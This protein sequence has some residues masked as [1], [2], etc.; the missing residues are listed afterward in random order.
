M[1]LLLFPIKT[2]TITEELSTLLSNQSIQT[3]I[4]V[5]KETVN[6]HLK[7]GQV[8]GLVIYADT[9][10]T[11]LGNC[12][13]D[14]SSWVQ[15][16]GVFV[17]TDEM[18]SIDR[19]EDGIKAGVLHH[20]LSTQI[21]LLPHYIERFRTNQQR[22]L[23]LVSIE[24]KITLA[25]EQFY[26]FFESFSQPILIHNLKEIILVNQAFLDTFGYE[27][28]TEIIGK[29]PLE[30]I[31]DVS[32][33]ATV[34]SVR[35]NIQKGKQQFVPRLKL[36]KKD[37]SRF[38]AEAEAS[39]LDL[40]GQ[41]FMQIILR[42]ISEQESIRLAEKK[43]QE[44]LECAQEL[45]ELGSWEYDIIKEELF[46]SKQAY[47]LFEIEAHHPPD[48]LYTLHKSLLHPDD[49]S[50]HRQAIKDVIE[51]GQAFSV[52]YRALT[53]KSGLKYILSKAI[54]VKNDAGDVVRVKGTFQNITER[55][56]IEEQLST[57][58]QN[59]LL[60]THSE[61]VPGI[62]YQFKLDTK[63]KMSFPF[64]G[65]GVVDLY[66]VQP[67]E[68][69]AM[70]KKIFKY[71]HEDDIE[72]FMASGQE[73][74]ATL[75]NWSFDYRICLPEKGIRWMH[76][77][78]KPV[79]LSD[80]STLWH[81]YISDVTEQKQKEQALKD[82][83]EQV[84]TLL[85][86]AP[87]AIIVL[88]MEGHIREWNPHAEL[89]FGWSKDAVLNKCVYDIV[90]PEHNRSRYKNS[91]HR[92]RDKQEGVVL[93]R[94]IEIKMLHKS[95]YEFPVVMA[96]SE[97]ILKGDVFFIL[98]INDISQYKDATAKIRQ[99]LKEKEV[100][101]K[102]IH[103]R[104]KNNLQ[105]VTSL[106][107]LQSS[108]IEDQ[109]IKE[110]FMQSQYRINSMGMVH[111]MLYQSVAI[112]SINYGS[113]LQRLSR[114]LLQAMR[115]RN[116]KICL[117]LKVEDI[118]LNIDTAVPLGLIVNEILTNALKYAFGDNDEGSIYIELKQLQ[119]AEF[120]L[121]IGDNGCGF[122]ETVDFKSAVSL[123]LMLIS[124][125]ARQLNGKIERLTKEEGTHY[126]LHFREIEQTA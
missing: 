2:S 30:T 87:S 111:E 29:L 56:K 59:N 38:L 32:S 115:G 27:D 58:K 123:G 122:G 92:Y 88:N 14:L 45:A 67:E 68:V 15:R 28:K 91:I 81:G 110:I 79:R 24:E 9:L 71:V 121:K 99:S 101:L 72:A 47:I 78:S 98:F 43:T 61:Q 54:A 76:G 22:Q 10:E 85:K 26:T 64:V 62:I 120:R 77:T 117:E 34:K 7:K 100:L 82:S 55:K 12:E 35:K 103:H 126:V 97:M 94:T 95:Q 33:Y 44:N 89:L 51:Q 104:V 11:I 42:N 124:K 114:R 16:L 50:I 21:I 112:S 80:G 86:H 106:L 119:T 105:V 40:N 75:N 118:N 13:A 46:L 60:L 102:E 96:V 107:S 113:Y 65:A 19:L 70:G 84:L 20:V 48:M 1:H 90:V 49:A 63:G 116:T 5:E 8:D 39:T 36:I 108:F 6:N 73:S 37:G 83:E 52:E 4:V 74:W 109:S 41:N 25:R 53:P 23:S 31:V 57:Q 3:S 125:L 69:M 18:P 93:N 66:G 17:I